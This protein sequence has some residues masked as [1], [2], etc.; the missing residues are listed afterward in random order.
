[1]S[2]DHK[3]VEI[4]TRCRKTLNEWKHQRGYKNYATARHLKPRLLQCCCYVRFTPGNILLSYSVDHTRLVRV[5]IQIE[6][7]GRIVAELDQSNLR[8]SRG[9]GECCG[10]VLSKG[11]YVIVPVTVATLVVDNACRLVEYEHNVGYSGW[12]RNS[13]K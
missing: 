7:D 8:L 4:R 12:A 1:M 2:L 11:E 10:Y 6:S 3:P 9:Y 13:C 5:L